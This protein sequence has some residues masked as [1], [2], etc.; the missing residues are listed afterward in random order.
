M[1]N[2]VTHEFIITENEML[3]MHQV[4]NDYT[5]IIESP[6]TIRVALKKGLSL[7]KV[8][9]RLRGE[10]EVSTLLRFMNAEVIEVEST[11]SNNSTTIA[12]VNIGELLGSMTIGNNNKTG[13]TLKCG[14][15]ELSYVVLGN[16][17]IVRNK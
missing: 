8:Y 12:E 10:R 6:T 7:E 1:K 15:Y 11:T 2:P 13:G 17:L 14:N 3:N 16:N 5:L 4:C 9:P